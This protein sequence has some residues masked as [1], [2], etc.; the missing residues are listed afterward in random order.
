MLNSYGLGLLDD[1]LLKLVE[2]LKGEECGILALNL[3]MPISTK[4][5]VLT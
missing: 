5:S 1:Q 2:I 3:G 4:T